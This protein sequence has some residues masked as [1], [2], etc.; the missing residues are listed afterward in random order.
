M[1]AKEKEN[2]PGRRVLSE[3]RL[4]LQFKEEEPDTVVHSAA[5]ILAVERPFKRKNC[6]KNA[7]ILTK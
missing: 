1:A 6:G 7:P 2:T 4:L 3:V 5:S